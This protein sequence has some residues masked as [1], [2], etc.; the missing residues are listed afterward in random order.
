MSEEEKAL[1]TGRVG[2]TGSVVETGSVERTEGREVFKSE[3]RQN[4]QPARG[5][6]QAAQTLLHGSFHS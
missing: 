1:K 5:P 4:N 6:S 2:R 3:R